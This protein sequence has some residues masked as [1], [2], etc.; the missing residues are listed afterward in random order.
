MSK[1]GKKDKEFIQS[2]YVDIVNRDGNIE[3]KAM[4]V[5]ENTEYY[6]VFD[7]SKDL[8][9]LIVAHKGPIFTG[10]YANANAIEG[11]LHDNRSDIYV[12]ITFDHDKA[13]QLNQ[14]PRFKVVLKQ[15]YE[16]FARDIFKQ[17]N[18]QA[19]MQE[20]GYNNTFNV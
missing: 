19:L 7:T 10:R 1:F 3:I 5:N 12:H 9:D 16:Y 17:L 8:S 6:I 2:N 13:K 4:P 20:K 14:E 18:E 15:E 11:A